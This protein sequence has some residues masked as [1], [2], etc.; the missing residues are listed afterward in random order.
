M[1]VPQMVWSLGLLISLTNATYGDIAGRS[2]LPKPPVVA[3]VKIVE[4]KVDGLSPNVVAKIVIPSSLLPDLEG[5]STGT[6]V[7]N[8]SP[9]AGKIGRAHV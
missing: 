7:S 8:D 9:P 5:S 3:P 4:G 2:P 1:S 6:R